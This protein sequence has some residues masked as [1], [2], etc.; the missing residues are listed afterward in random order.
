MVRL[1]VYDPAQCCST[2]VCGPAVD[3]VLV[4]FAADLEW[5]RARGV[6]VRRFNLAQEAAEFARSALVRRKL[7]EEGTGCLPL[8]LVGTEVV[9]S[10]R[11][12]SRR[13]LG[14]WSEIA[15]GDQGGPARLATGEKREAVQPRPASA[16]L[17]V[18]E[19]RESGDNGSPSCS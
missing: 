2:G 11:Y 13:E 5:L 6:E 10:G 3:P 7:Q 12:P 16:G 4:R 18:L 1:T 14:A 15:G 19:G 9:S 17:V 8:L